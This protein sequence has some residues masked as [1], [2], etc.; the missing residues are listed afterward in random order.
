[1]KAL[2]LLSQN[3]GGV[4]THESVFTSRCELLLGWAL[5]FA[6]GDR[7]AAEDLVQDTFVR[8]VVSKPDLA[9]VESAEALLYTYLKYV[10]L[11][12]LRRA[13]NYQLQTLS[14][15]EFD[16]LRLGLRETS[17]LNP[18]ASDAQNIAVD[19]PSY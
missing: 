6:N 1:M 2:G 17:A 18:I 8:F 16:E 9:A 5:H 7:A 19:Y 14:I 4:E 13:Q 3:A 10:H 12:H 11:A 15:V